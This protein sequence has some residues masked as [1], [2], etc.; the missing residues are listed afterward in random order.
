MRITYL[1]ISC[2]SLNGDPASWEAESR[3]EEGVSVIL[4]G[5]LM[6]LTGLNFHTSYITHIGVYQPVSKA[7][8]LLERAVVV[9]A[10]ILRWSSLSIGIVESTRSQ[11]CGTKGQYVKIQYIVI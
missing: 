2:R 11:Q 4:G 7:M 5:S 8:E 9:K 3:A 1:K 6:R 10:W